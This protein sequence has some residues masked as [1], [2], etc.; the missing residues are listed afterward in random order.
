MPRDQA[1]REDGALG[2]EWN[3]GRERFPG[4]FTTSYFHGPDELVAEV[5]ESGLILEALIGI[6]APG[7]F[8]GDGW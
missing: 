1:R 5:V 8:V 3:P 4:W 6:E 7:G 2:S